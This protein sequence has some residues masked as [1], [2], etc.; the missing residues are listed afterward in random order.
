VVN[1]GKDGVEH[2]GYALT[3]ALD[4]VVKSDAS[5]VLDAVNK[6]MD[7]TTRHLRELAAGTS[8]TVPADSVIHLPAGTVLPL[9]ESTVVKS[10]FNLPAVFITLAV[11]MLLVIG[12]SESAT[13]NNIIVAIKVTVIL[14]FIG[15]GALY[16]F[17]VGMGTRLFQVLLGLPAIF[18]SLAIFVFLVVLGS[19]KRL[20]GSGT[21]PVA[22][23]QVESLTT[24]KGV[25]YQRLEPAGKPAAKR[26]AIVFFHGGAWAIGDP[27]QFY[28]QCDYLA[29]RGL[30]AASAEYRL[31]APG[32][33]VKISKISALADD[34]AMAM[35]AT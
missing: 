19:G 1:A 9:A 21:V 16:G 23:R 20:F 31:T 30:W 26:P 18:V 17:I 22:L 11:T 4:M 12:V 29:K 24:E 27:N 10:L 6:V 5:A 34:I 3:N 35:K 32:A 8:V 25:V 13:V 2:S 28:Y 7:P 14:A 33:G 15:V